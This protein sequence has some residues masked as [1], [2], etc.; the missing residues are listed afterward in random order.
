MA[1]ADRLGCRPKA[2]GA[3][4]PA[5]HG[6]IGPTQPCLHRGFFYVNLVD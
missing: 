2:S 1:E 6:D 4:Q 5:T 3:T